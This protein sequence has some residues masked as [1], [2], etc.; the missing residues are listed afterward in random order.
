VNGF[1]FPDNEGALAGRFVLEISDS[2]LDRQRDE[3][4]FPLVKLV[5]LI[6]RGVRTCR[7]RGAQFSGGDWGRGG[8]SG[9]TTGG[10]SE[11]KLRF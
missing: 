9:N 3:S 8:V 4:Y 6:H 11:T 7:A 10:G 2:L 1:A 5:S